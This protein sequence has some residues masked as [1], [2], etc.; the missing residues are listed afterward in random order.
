[1]STQSHRSD[2]ISNTRQAATQVLNGLANL[3]KC[4]AAW[5]GRGL[6]AQIV[7]A[8]GTDPNAEGYKANDFVGNEGLTKIDINQALMIALPA[9]RTVI[10]SADGKKLEDIA[11]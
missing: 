10:Q 8:T 3:E 2:V 9:L 11:I 7:D 1:M 4:L 5:D 6:K